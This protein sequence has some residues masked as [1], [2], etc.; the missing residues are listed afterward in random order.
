[1]P[2]LFAR[3]VGARFALAG[4][5]GNLKPGSTRR[6]PRIV[7]TVFDLVHESSGIGVMLQ[8]EV[9]QT[10]AAAVPNSKA[11]AGSGSI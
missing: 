2:H 3:T 7:Q 9:E 11:V 5:S 10:P 1:M 6:Q 4:P 8:Q